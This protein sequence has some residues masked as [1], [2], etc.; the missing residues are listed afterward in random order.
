MK[1]GR[2]MLF[3]ED[4]SSRSRTRIPDQFM[5]SELAKILYKVN[6]KQS[7]KEALLQLSNIISRRCWS[8]YIYSRNIEEE[9]GNSC[10]VGFR[11]GASP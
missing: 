2:R 1:E 4:L 3:H 11:S 10:V 6:N 8:K 5:E 7:L 9:N